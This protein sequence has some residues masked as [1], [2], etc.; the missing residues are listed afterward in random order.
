MIRSLFIAATGMEAQTLKIDV[1][2]NNLANANTAGYKRSRA[3]FQELMYQDVMTPG[4][5]SAEGSQV[6]SGIQIGLGVKPV[7]VQK[8]FEEGELVNTGNPLDLA[9]EGDGFFQI[10]KPDGEIA[11]SRAGTFKLDSEG[12][13]VNSE[14]YLLEPEI[15]IPPDATQITVGSDGKVT[16]LQ[17]G[18]TTPVEVGQIEIAKF[19]NPGGLKAIGRNLFVETPSS[20]APITGVP[21]EDGLGTIQ[22]G[23]VE[24]S[25]VNIVEEM[26]QMI[27][28]QR[29]YEM[30]SKAIQASDEMLQTANN[31]RR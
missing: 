24:L 16:V 11:Y 29:A 31:L 13:I 30:N 9:I 2:A 26:I 10:V 1:I 21:G 4:A 17:P 14:G 12:R 25:N 18:S 19:P 27:I 3:D 28:S 15:T 5:I 23:F 20:G 6:P 7:A 8:I 22:Q